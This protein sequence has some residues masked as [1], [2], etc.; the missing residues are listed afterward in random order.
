RRPNHGLAA[1]KVGDT[2]DEQSTPQLGIKTPAVRFKEDIRSMERTTERE[3]AQFGC[4]HGHGAAG[5]AE[6]IVQMNQLALSHTFGNKA[7]FQKVGKLVEESLKPGL[8]CGPR[9]A[10][11][12]QVASG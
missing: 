6:M 5:S 11:R 8:T 10:Q 9:Q 1:T 2:A 3:S 7:R 12:A 4:Q